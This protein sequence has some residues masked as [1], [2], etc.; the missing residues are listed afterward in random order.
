MGPKGHI[1]LDGCRED[2]VIRVLED[3]TYMF[4]KITNRMLLDIQ[5]SYDYITF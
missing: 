1:L 5:A 4:C 3:K 2:L